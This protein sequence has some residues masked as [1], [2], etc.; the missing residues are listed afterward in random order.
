MTYIPR[1]VKTTPHFEDVIA[2]R[3]IKREWCEKIAIDRTYS[4][5]M[6]SG[7]IRCW[8]WVEEI[9]RYLRVVILE[10]GE[11]LHTA[12]IDSGFKWGSR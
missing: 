2:L 4:Q 11:T 7:R 5:T 10:D 6:P 8:G 9:R 12:M 1:V 3:N